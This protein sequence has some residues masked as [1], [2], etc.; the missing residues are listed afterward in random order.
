MTKNFKQ[1]DI[2]TILDRE[3]GKLIPI[4]GEQNEEAEATDKPT[5]IEKRLFSAL[6]TLDTLHN[7]ICKAYLALFPDDSVKTS[8]A[9]DY[10]VM[11]LQKITKKALD[12][13]VLAKK[14]E[15]CECGKENSCKKDESPK[16]E[17]QTTETK[18]SKKPK[19]T[20]KPTA[21]KTQKK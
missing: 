2:P 11:L 13:E 9:A 19:T 14:A 8:A 6:D 4:F 21:R 18:A 5:P 3:T 16:T 7:E 10:F 17:Q 1:E 15:S 12:L 20:K